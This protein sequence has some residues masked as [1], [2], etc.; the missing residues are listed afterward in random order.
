MRVFIKRN[1]QTFGPYPP[2]TLQLYLE[3]GSILPQD[4]AK[5]DSEPDTA[6]RPLGKLMRQH[7]IVSPMLSGTFDPARVLGEIRSFQIEFLF[8][9]KDIQSGKWLKDHRVLSFVAVGMLPVVF[10]SLSPS[11]TAV[12]WCLALYFASIWSMYFY[13]MFR[14]PE[15]N[16]K[17]ALI[18]FAA[19]IF[20]GMPI[21]LIVQ[22]IPPMSFLYAMAKSSNLVAR[23]LGMFLGVGISEEL[24]KAA[25]VYYFASRPGSRLT[26][27]RALAI[28][29]GVA[30]LQACASL[31]GLSFLVLSGKLLSVK[32]DWPANQ[33]FL[34]GGIAIA[35]VSVIAALTQQRLA[36]GT[37][38]HATSADLA[39]REQATG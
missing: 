16:V 12:Y 17:T 11:K 27:P 33:I 30:W 37:G 9:W 7:Q 36:R 15:V 6:W 19:T 1:E 13:Q 18:C 39:K 34:T 29:T 2:P 5:L 31:V 20:A 8:P 10:V 4:L 21:V 26:S 25:A 23:F 32:G 3:Q 28:S 35:A 24:C 38:E 14:T 22:Q